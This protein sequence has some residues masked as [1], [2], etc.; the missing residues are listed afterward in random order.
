ML[1][2]CIFGASFF[3]QYTGPVGGRL[4]EYCENTVI[5]KM[6]SMGGWK[7]EGNR[8]DLVMDQMQEMGEAKS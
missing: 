7:T 5:A 1:R 2:F 6:D 3:I 8:Q 4:L